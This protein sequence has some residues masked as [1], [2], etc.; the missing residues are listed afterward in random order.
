MNCRCMLRIIYGEEIE[1][2]YTG[3]TTQNN[4]QTA[5]R[6]LWYPFNINESPLSLPS[7]RDESSP[8]SLVVF[9]YLTWRNTNR[10]LHSFLKHSE[11]LGG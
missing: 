9:H 3:Y 10:A 1:Y 4:S 2:V 5:K 6:R 8:K 7:R 11:T